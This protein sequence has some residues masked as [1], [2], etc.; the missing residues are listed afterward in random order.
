ME[1]RR[2]VNR[3]PLLYFTQVYDRKSRQLIGYLVDISQK[4]G[5]LVTEREIPLDTAIHLHID[6]PVSFEKNML[7]IASRVIWCEPD[8]DSN[9]Y[10]TGVEWV[11][12]DP[13]V[14][15]LFSNLS[16]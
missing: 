8:P 1:E 13:E 14:Q 10:K 16:F 12:L 4:G 5:Q 7:N 2:S 11:N 15:N 6:F 3:K 9:F